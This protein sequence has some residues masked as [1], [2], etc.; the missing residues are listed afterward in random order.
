MT[1]LLCDSE[2]RM[3]REQ[4]TAMNKLKDRRARFEMRVSETQ[5]IV[6]EFKNRE[7]MSDAP[8]YVEVFDQL[9]K[10]VEEFIAEVFQLWFCFS[11]VLLL[12][13]NYSGNFII[14]FYISL[15][16]HLKKNSSSNGFLQLATFGRH[17]SLLIRSLLRFMHLYT[18][19]TKIVLIA[20][21]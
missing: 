2:M 18:F 3:L 17:H 7:R 12:K 15:C 11:E 20:D 19:H 13:S 1:V 21:I 4:E 5:R 6:A 16:F 9:K 10:R 8:Q 14:F